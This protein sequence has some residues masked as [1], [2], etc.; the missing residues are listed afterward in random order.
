MSDKPVTLAAVAGAHGIKGEVRLKLFAQSPE[1]LARHKSVEVSGRTLTLI[2]VRPASGGAVAR[3]AE[4][5]DRSSAEA[6][7]G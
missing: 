2:S 4:V 5:G 1:S 6:L 3:F 7:R